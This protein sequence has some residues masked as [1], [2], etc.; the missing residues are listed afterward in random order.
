[1]RSAELSFRGLGFD[2]DPA[3]REPVPS[4][5][6]TR[7]LAGAR[8]RESRQMNMPMATISAIAPIAIS[9]AVEPLSPLLD[10]D[11]PVRVTGADAVDVAAVPGLGCRGTPGL[12]GLPGWA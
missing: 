3:R 2:F 1:L 10:D 5:A 12:N 8:R 4:A 9:A 11:E 7:C 6:A